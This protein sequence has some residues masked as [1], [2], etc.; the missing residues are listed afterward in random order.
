M[1][2]R[3]PTPLSILLT[4][5]AGGFTALACAGIGNADPTPSLYGT[6]TS[7]DG[8]SNKVFDE[9]GRCKGFFY[10]DGKPL[11]IGGPMSCQLSSKPTSSGRYQLNVTQGPNEATYLVEFNGDD[12]ATVYTRSGSKL[13]QL[14]R[15]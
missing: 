7:S 14:E 5:F 15:F 12:A 1:R 13:Y 4:M 2:P 10:D 11:D 9:D 3:T 8:T 6:W